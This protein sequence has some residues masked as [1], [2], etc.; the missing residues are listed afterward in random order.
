MSFA[1]LGLMPELLQA[2]ADAG[3]T[4]A[5]PIQKQAIP[6]V[7]AGKDV[8]GGAQTG[9]GKTAGFTL[10]LL[11]RLARHQNTSLSP[12]RHPVRALI[13]CPTRELAMQVHESVVTY[14]RHLALRSV[15]I[16][17]GVDMK[18]QM[19][20]LRLGR[21][22]VV[23]TP[24]RLLDHIEQKTVNFQ[25]VEVLVLDEAD[26]M[27]DM[28][29]IPDVKRILALLPKERQSLLF[30]ATFSDE[31]KKLA[32]A[33][34]RQ[35]QLIEVARRNALAETVTHQVHPV[36]QEQ[37]RQLL[38]HIVKSKELAQALVF[39]G[40]KFGCSRLA[41][42]L[43]RQGI[44]ADAIHGDKS[45]QQRTEALEAFKAGR[46]RVLVATDVA[47]RGLDI[48]DL[49][50]VINFEL[51]HTP[52]DYV[53]RIGRTGRAG[54]EGNAISLVCAEERGRLADIEK[55]IKRPLER[56]QVTGFEPGAEF[57]A[58]REKGRRGRGAR[59]ESEAAP[60][61]P[62]RPGREPRRAPPPAPA[63]AAKGKPA[64][65]WSKPYEPPPDAFVEPPLPATPH[66]GHKPKR[67]IAALLGG[68]PKKGQ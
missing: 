51:P 52:E 5:T 42:Y 22:I 12:A 67:Q 1:E 2:V 60:P 8:L 6:V 10:P 43:V 55:L 29:F 34:L 59:R 14:S 32:D 46:T 18:A 28:G 66:P 24:G 61:R 36:P 53:H 13:L 21:E 17:G 25:S 23:A 11:Q 50:Y 27:L 3:Y 37:K 64:F 45:Q 9:T 35:P 63:S 20:Q 68:L 15:V 62:A 40:T 39:V 47:A 33:M 48:D 41:H 31:I 57:S 58:P 44:A 26:R 56:V 7:L 65:D 30:S 49:P 38:A 16:Y 54:K 4:E 19:E